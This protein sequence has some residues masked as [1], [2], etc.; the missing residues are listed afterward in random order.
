MPVTVLLAE[1]DR[2]QQEFLKTLLGDEM[3]Y[4]V[5]LAS[6]GK[7][8][9]RILDAGHP[10][11]IAIFDIGM[12]EM[13]GLELLDICGQKY[14]SL[15]V[16]ILTGAQDVGTAIKTMQLGAKDFLTKPPDMERLRVSVENALRADALQKEVTRFRKKEKG[17]FTFDQIVG[18]DRGLVNVITVGR[19][20]AAADIPVLITG[21]TGVGKEV[22]ASAIHGE[23]ARGGKP[24]IAINCGAIPENLVE[25][26]LFGHEKG[27]FTGADKKFIGKFREADG[28]TIFLDEIGEL[29]M[30]AQ[31]KLL[32]VLQQKEVSAV[33]GTKPVPV[34]VRIISATN[35]NLKAEVGAGR[36]RE[37]LYFRLGVLPIEIP[38]LSQRKE[39]IPELIRYFIRRYS[40][41]EGRPLK[42]LSNEAESLMLNH[43]WTGNVRELENVIYRAIIVTEGGI[44]GADDIAPLLEHGDM[45]G[46]SAAPHIPSNFFVNADGSLKKLDQIEK[47]AIDFALSYCDGSVIQAAEL[48]GVAKTTIYRKIK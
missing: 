5:L 4:K 12:P 27:A 25:S 34:N 33:G 46:L 18:Y 37:D 35:R 39:D 3:S 11:D 22:L 9:L 42:S 28:G 24:F 45:G 2:S 14:P 17:S 7:E 13:D 20:A 26:T 1:D 36:F 30:S 41:S 19:K 32:R 8:A 43:G 47:E 48:L 10:V 23:S 31:V 40:L 16:I 21:R 44:I 38:A 6:N 29:P 15:P